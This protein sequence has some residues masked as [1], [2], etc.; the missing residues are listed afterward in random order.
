M[1]MFGLVLSDTDLSVDPDNVDQRTD[2]IGNYTT[3]E[4][5][6]SAKD[7]VIKQWV[8]A[9]D[10]RDKPVYVFYTELP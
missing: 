7:T 4:E 3:M 1:F 6:E 9:N 2:V 5:L 10:M 8:K